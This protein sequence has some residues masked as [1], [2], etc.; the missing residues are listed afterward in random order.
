ME[1]LHNKITISS[2]ELPTLENSLS[3]K[4]S[5]SQV[6]NI[7]SFVTLFR[8]TCRFLVANS[9]RGGHRLKVVS[10]FAMIGLAP[11]TVQVQVLT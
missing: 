11:C 2:K 8:F 9:A 1:N 10:H 3:G 5:F 6:Q 4:I 7:S